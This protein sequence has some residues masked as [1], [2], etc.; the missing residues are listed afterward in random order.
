MLVVGFP[1]PLDCAKLVTIVQ[2]ALW[3][4]VMSSIFVLQGIIAWKV[5][6]KKYSVK[7]VVILRLIYLQQQ[8]APFVL[9][10]FS[11]HLDLMCHC[12][13]FMIALLDITVHLEH[14]VEISMGVHW[15]LTALFLI[16]LVNLNV[17]PVVEVDIVEFLDSTVLMAQVLVPL[18][19]FASNR[20]LH[21]PQLM[22]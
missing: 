16:E 20:H 1:S 10:D 9:R 2:K 4:P 18:D 13:T 17:C 8:P 12:L 11:V 15:E 21:Q 22:V 19:T 6:S 7:E 3:F 14:L 5:V